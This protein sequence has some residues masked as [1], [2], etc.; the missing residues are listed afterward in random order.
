MK[1]TS[2]MLLERIDT[3]KP[4]EK[5]LR[6]VY[7]TQSVCPPEIHFQ[8]QGDEVKEVRFVGGGCPGN[9]QLVSRFLQDRP[10]NDVLELIG[11][12]TCRNGTSCPDQLAKALKATMDGSLEPARSFKVYSDPEP[13]KRI[14]LI[15]DLGGHS[16]LLQ[17]LIENIHKEEVEIIYSLG[18]M[19]GNSANNEDLIKRIRK[20]EILVIQGELDFRYANG[21]EPPGFHGLN[22]KERDYLVR[23]PQVLSFRLGEKKGMAFFGKYIR[24]L[25]DFSDFEP[26]ALEM[27]MVCD[28][29]Q[30]LKDETVFP[31]LEAMVPQFSAQVILFSQIRRWGRWQIG[32]IDFISI[33]PALNDKGLA[34]GL[35][36]RNGGEIDF[37]ILRVE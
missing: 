20:E 23:L 4:D 10:V 14:G 26:F 18:N 19:T 21:Q 34:W 29:T 11:E 25:P 33:G 22:Q 28:L 6:Y 5:I 30:F 3:L 2:P 8:I 15:G 36:E 35:L 9:A 37:N 16:E 31:A 27:N 17:G 7:P 32:G 12:I 1:D 24:D 13:R